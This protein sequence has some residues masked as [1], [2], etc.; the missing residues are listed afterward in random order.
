M[1]LPTRPFHNLLLAAGILL[2]LG[3]VAGTLPWGASGARQD[4]SPT[5]EAM[6]QYAIQDEYS[7]RA[8]YEAI[9][10]TFGQTRPFSNIIRSEEAHI[11][12]LKDA[13]ASRNLA[14]P[15]DSSAQ[16]VRVPPTL[17]G[18]L[19]VGVQA[20]ID[21]IAMYDRFLASDPLKRPENASLKL[22]FTRL[23]DASKNHLAAFQRGLARS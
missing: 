11:Q 3:L 19:A 23:R 7:A 20:E 13:Y 16:H 18:A 1:R 9:M 12:W 22:L 8:E 4:S 10:G 17:K 21:N 15:A 2:P 5:L 14:V 6:M